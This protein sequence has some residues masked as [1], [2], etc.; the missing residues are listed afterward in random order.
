[1]KPAT[2]K[3]IKVFKFQYSKL[4]F[5]II[6]FYAKRLNFFFVEIDI[7]YILTFNLKQTFLS[8]SLPNKYKNNIRKVFFAFLKFKT[9]KLQF[10]SALLYYI[11]EQEY[12]LK[13]VTEKY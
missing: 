6:L 1:M 8:P 9:K 5:L 3:M 13:I 12:S 2:K 10:V 11:I 7:M 4:A